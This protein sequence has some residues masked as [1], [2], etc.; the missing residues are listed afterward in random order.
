MNAANHEAL[1]ASHFE[2]RAEKTAMRIARLRAA[3]P[4]LLALV[5]TAA[6]VLPL[7]WMVIG[8][9]KGTQEFFA[10]PPTWYPHDPQF[11]NYVE[12][13][14]RIPFLQ[15]L[16][17]SMFYALVSAF[18][19]CLSAAIVAYGFA[20]LEWK[21]RDT[22]FG[23][24]MLTMFLPYQVTMIPTYLVFRAAGL[25]DSL[26]P[27]IIP[28]FLGNAFFIFLM[29]QFMRT[30]PDEL[31]DAARLDGCSEFG[32]FFRIVLPLVRPAL[33]VVFLNQFLN[34]WKDFLGPLIYVTDDTKWPLSLALQQ[35]QSAQ[36]SEVS[37]ILACATVFTLPLLVIFLFTQ[38]YFIEGVTFSG[39][40][41]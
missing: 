40:K 10:R 22:A 5:V 37:L 21:G 31:L 16:K 20:K 41:G 26:W 34:A 8:S 38:R 18:G 2:Q 14:T 30:L 23:I 7:Y 17:N 24:V 27:L 1:V 32:V 11:G 35:F 6:F 28:A 25:S 13:V 3:M 36:D 19:A 29:R 4:F 39:L 9:L 12:A 15:Y 33:V